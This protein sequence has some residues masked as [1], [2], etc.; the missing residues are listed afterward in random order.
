[1]KP[2]LNTTASV[3]A[4]LAAALTAVPAASQAGAV[5]STLSQADA[6]VQVL[7]PSAAALARVRDLSAPITN[8]ARPRF[9]DVWVEYGPFLEIQPH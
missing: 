2:R 1:M 6:A 4:A 5:S 3:A 9:G 7:Q 8:P